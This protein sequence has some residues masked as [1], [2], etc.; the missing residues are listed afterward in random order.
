MHGQTMYYLMHTQT[1]DAWPCFLFP[2]HSSTKKRG[3]EDEASEILPVV[4][5]VNDSLLCAYR[6]S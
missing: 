3:T 4:V 2:R 5:M 1:V 6:Y